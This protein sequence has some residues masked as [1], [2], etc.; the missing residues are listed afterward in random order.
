MFVSVVIGMFSVGTSAQTP[1]VDVTFTSTTAANFFKTYGDVAV[2]TSSALSAGSNNNGYCIKLDK[3]VDGVINQ[4]YLEV[5]SSG[6]AISKIELDVTA[7]SSNASIQPTLLGW[8]SSASVSSATNTADYVTSVSYQ[9]GS[10]YNVGSA[11]STVTFDLSGQD[12]KAVR[13]F[14]MVKNMYIDGSSSPTSVGVGQTVR[15]WGFRV[16]LA[17]SGPKAPVLSISNN[18][19]QSV[20]QGNAISNIVVTSDKAA[21]FNLTGS[22][23]TGVSGTATDSKTYTIS[24]SSNVIGNYTY[25]VTA[26]ADGLTSDA[27]GGTISVVEGPAL[28]LTNG[29]QEVMV[30][31]AITNIVVTSDNPSTTFSVTGLPAGVTG[32]GSGSTYTISG[33]PTAEGSFNFVVSGTAGGNT[34]TVNG[35]ITVTERQE[36]STNYTIN[37]KL[38]AAPTTANGGIP[39]ALSGATVKAYVGGSSWTSSGYKFG[40]N[41]DTLTIDLTNVDGAYITG[42]SFPV[43]M[44]ST[45]TIAYS[46]DDVDNADDAVYESVS[47]G[48]SGAT[49]TI[50]CPSYAKKLRLRRNVGSGTT[51]GNILLTVA[52]GVTLPPVLF[53]S[54]NKTQSVSQGKAIESIVVTSDKP[55]TFNAEGLPA[56]VSGNTSADGL[57]YTISGVPTQDGA[58][59]YSVT[60]TADGKT[61]VAVGGTLTVVQ[62]PVLNIT[63]ASQTTTNGT[64]IKTIQITSNDGETT[65]SVSGLPSGVTG[66]GSGTSF[67]ISGTPTAVGTFQ[68][69]VTGTLGG[70]SKTVNGTIIVQP[71]APKLTAS[72]NVE[73]E[74][75]LNHAISTITITSDTA[76]SF[77][78]SCLPAGVVAIAGADSTR[79][80][81]TGKATML[82]TTSFSVVA[83]AHGKGK[84]SNS[85]SGQITVTED[86]VAAAPVL[87]PSASSISVDKGVAITDL[88]ITSDVAAT[89]AIDKALPA[90]LTG[91]ASADGLTYTISG[92]PTAVSASSV[93]TISATANELTAEQPIT[94]AV[95][96]VAPVV[97]VPSNA[98]QNVALGEAIGNISFSSSDA[99]AVFSVEG[100]PAGL[101]ATQNGSTYI[102]S[103]TATAAGEFTYTVTATVDGK[104]ATKS[105]V[106]TIAATAPT[107][108][109]SADKTSVITGSKVALTVTPVVNNSGATVEKVVITEGATIIATLTGA[110][111]QAEY[112]VATAGSHV[113]TA[114]VTDSYGYTG[115]NTVT[116]AG[117]DATAPTVELSANKTAVNVGGSV[118]LSAST[119]LTN[120]T[121][122]TSTVIKNGTNTLVTNNGA[123]ASYVF[124][125]QY[126]GTYKFT[127]EGTDNNGMTGTSDVV[128]ITVSPNAPVLT[129]TA[130]AITANKL[131]AVTALKIMSD[132]AATWTIDKALP[133]GL[134]G[135]VSA[136]GKTYTISG[137]P[138][139]VQAATSYTVKATTAS[140]TS[141]NQAVTITV[142]AVAPVVAAPSNATQNVALGEAIGN[143]SFSSSDA[144]AVFSVEGLP[145][146]L[147]ATQN[148]STYIISG[149][150]TA[151]G[152]FTYT[153][154]ATV[155]GK[156]ATKSGVI[157]IAATAP[158]VTLSADKTSVITGSKVA[159]TAIPVVK[160]S[161][162]TVKKVVITEGSTVIATLTGA[163]YQAEYTVA[164]AGSH[165]L[166][167]TVTDSYDYTGTNTVT[168]AG[169]DAT[170]PA[171][172]LSA[173]KTAIGVGESV[174][175][176]ANTTLTNGT[177]VT[178]TVIKNGT[179]TSV[180]ATGASATYTFTPT[181]AGTYK[182]TAEGT[183]NNGQ[184]GVS[185]V[186]TIVVTSVDPEVS[187]SS[188]ETSVLAG[189]KVTL[190]AT[191]SAN[192]VNSTVKNVVITEGETVI[193]TLTAA[194]Y[195]TEFTVT[196]G[197]HILKATVTDSYGYT[198]ASTLTVTG[199]AAENPTVVLS[200]S[201]TSVF[202]GTSVTLT[203]TPAAITEGATITKVEIA[204]GENV[205]ATLTSA[206]YTYEYTVT[207]GNHVLTAIVTD[208][209]YMTGTDNITIVG[210]NPEGPTVSLVATKESIELGESVT[211]TATTSLGN[212]GSSV[213]KTVI[214]D[215]NGVIASENS[216]VATFN[217]TPTTA[218]TYKFL[219][220]GVDNNDLVGTSSEII[221]TVAEPTAPTA[222]IGVDN[223]EVEVGET[224]TITVDAQATAAG[225]TI[226]KV[227][228]ISGASVIA[229][230]TQAPYEYEFTA[231]TA[232]DYKFA[233]KVIDSN[234]SSFVTGEVTITVNEAQIVTPTV[235]TATIGVDN[236]EVEVGEAA[237]ITVDAQATAEGATIEKVEIISG[238]SVIATLT[239]APYEYEFTATTAGDYKFA[240]KVI[241]SNSSSFVTGEV[242]ITVNETLPTSVSEN[243]SSPVWKQTEDLVTIENIEVK[244]MWLFSASGALISKVDG[245]S[246]DVSMMPNGERFIVAAKVAGRANLISNK[247]IK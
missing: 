180:S 197:D 22:L 133:A 46:F 237:I 115:T 233:A 16:Y 93:Y 131:S 33:T 150:A 82:E 127:A 50:T 242:T 60:A 114:T 172:V 229:T 158:T 193:A 52:T 159:L 10:T 44:G 86:A 71:A 185:D 49:A 200:S 129:A 168:V 212:G 55:A 25:S 69:V 147:T 51:V 213:K 196:E 26:T 215:A 121:S 176:S 166:T 132:S 14:R 89:W 210:N 59:T 34:K 11:A 65:Y 28:N 186:V 13:I 45:Y 207:A 77:S 112:T 247:F 208:S 39:A 6:A 37:T 18:A 66:S 228:I 148:G 178:S 226:E 117:V 19:T 62:G 72:S 95:N 137:T 138:T 99:D 199:I 43:T 108:T 203:A 30:G 87:T 218:G 41:K 15:V 206:P 220:E 139:A 246:I 194:P 24:G 5:V 239:Q 106:I 17:A 177:S 110:P 76:V 214:K 9:G 124:T 56:G 140:G 31:N 111:Y 90:G 142:N 187:L 225:A 170:A 67:A 169:V 97:T 222:T 149:T 20:S 42:A 96:A 192:N 70:Y 27:V 135:T 21:T 209:Y 101:T 182:F 122:V 240:A 211:L 53:I 118:T 231:T 32:S 152:E 146:G 219:A 205:I 48:A 54:G 144:D 3:T 171:V 126:A 153:V 36:T 238:A 85:I 174:S 195:E 163:P 103:G 107:V 216:S 156:S 189:T 40:V 100:L 102:I 109:L 12:L 79:L 223:D 167:A 125:A 92:T 64:A 179:E 2:A 221:I 113:L 130:T 217:F 154:T 98:T 184:I 151:A 134:T 165:V 202:A 198:A 116:V 230:L 188:D 74:V 4:G 120:G 123:S 241:D 224:V 141:A 181:T 94:I 29:T 91:T 204:E 157:T 161:G 235:P 191:A 175:L 164:T 236:D 61:S 78:I 68:Y 234:S 244:E 75:Q 35:T 160:N 162:A 105:G 88:V 183:D 7:N 245:N 57:T 83:K 73:Q 190:K 145:A 23:P 8:E 227:E 84:Q 243:S 38:S 201:A 58:F 143:I 81:I 104:S 173:D 1:D 136:D 119:T 63:N 232:G 155:D 128:T 47:F 80:I